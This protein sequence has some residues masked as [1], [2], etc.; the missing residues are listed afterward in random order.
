MESPPLARFLSSVGKIQHHLHTVVVGLSAVERGEANKPDDLDITW[1]ARDRIGSSREARR[2]LLRATLV[3]IIEELNEF[4][5]SVLRYRALEKSE[6]VPAERAARIRA[7]AF[8]Q[9]IEPDYLVLAP[10]ILIHWRNRIVH[11]SSTARLASSE[12][13]LLLSHK[14]AVR[15]A[16]KAIDVTRLLQDFEEDRPSLKD[17]TVLLAM[18]I[19]FARAVDSKL[20]RPANTEA[21]RQ[22]LESEGLL[23]KIL[24]LEKESKNGGDLD[25][26]SKRQAIPDYKGGRF[27]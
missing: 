23:D 14:D 18:S 10:L 20:P 13:D 21:V 19:K 12:R 2:F 9:E 7:L 11:R 24:A 27:G 4:A 26:R 22:W 3:F 6:A 25:P 15:D 17:V 1:T 16:F 5:I 8:S